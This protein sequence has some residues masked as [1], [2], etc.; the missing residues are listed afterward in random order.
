M[1]QEDPGLIR[2]SNETLFAGATGIVDRQ[3]NVIRGVS[4]ITG[5]V[6][7]EGHNLFVDKTTV[8]QLLE[9]SRKM[10]KVPVTVNHNGGVED[11][12]GWL[13]DFRLDGNNLRADWHLLET[14]AETPVMMERAEKQPETFGLS[15]SFC[16]DPKGT[17]VGN[18]QCARAE[19]V[20]S[21]DV[22]RHA[23]ANP[24]GLFSALPCPLDSD[25]KRAIIE[26][27]QAPSLD[28]RNFS[29]TSQQLLFNMPN[30]PKNQEP[31]LADILA[32]VQ[33]MATRLE[34]A[35]QQNAAIIAHL[36]GQGQQ[37]SQ[38]EQ[39]ERENQERFELLSQLNAM[40]DEDLAAEGITRDQVDAEVAAY[41]AS[42]GG[43]SQEQGEQQQGGEHGGE[44]FA[45]AGAETSAGTSGAAFSA[46]QRQV[47][48]LSNEIKAQK[49]RE[50]KNAEAIEFEAVDKKIIGLAAQRDEAIEL[51]TKLVAENEA[52]R[53]HVK[54]GTR[55]APAG[56]EGG[57]LFSAMNS[58]E[59]HPW[60]QKVKQIELSQKVSPGKAIQLCDKEDGG[61]LHRD[62]INSLAKDR[63][64]NA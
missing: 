48:S 33:G 35:E 27:A 37:L 22:V 30:D 62:Y 7:A 44:Q 60:Q 2:F 4:C 38:E 43:Q 52:L 12:D 26:L 18:R 63:T 9:L 11:V 47:I 36:N 15:Y 31:S 55:P 17:T 24:Q 45:G 49:V 23:A 54:T 34:A 39:A 58:G 56:V 13:Q 40:S 25:L 8:M 16:G 61:A 42:V 14:H 29:N 50:A 10:G 5:E 51:A 59:L 6:A 57:I 32:A 1:P 20:K 64:I 53:L 41:N 19:K 21:C 46:L 28:S 3:N